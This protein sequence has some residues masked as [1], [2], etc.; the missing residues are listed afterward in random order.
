MIQTA[1][2]IDLA[3]GATEV[4]PQEEVVLATKGLK[5]VETPDAVTYK[6]E[7]YLVLIPKN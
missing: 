4:L 2:L 1:Y 5:K 3:T 6:G 7:E